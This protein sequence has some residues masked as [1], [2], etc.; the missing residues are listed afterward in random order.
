MNKKDKQATK[1]MTKIDQQICL[2][3]VIFQTFQVIGQLQLRL[4]ILLLGS[5]HLWI[6]KKNQTDSWRKYPPS[7]VTLTGDKNTTLQGQSKS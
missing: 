6:F 7:R 4:G 1:L 3:P 5:L 2:K